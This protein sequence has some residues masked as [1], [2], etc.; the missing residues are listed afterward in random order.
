MNYLADFFDIFGLA[1]F[2]LL[3]ITAIWSLKAFRMTI[4]CMEG[5]QRGTL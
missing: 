4:G 5:V 3:F 1:T 2:S